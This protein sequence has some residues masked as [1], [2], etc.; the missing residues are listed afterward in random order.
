MTPDTS[1]PVAEALSSSTP[2]YVKFTIGTTAYSYNGNN[3]WFS[4]SANV[5]TQSASNYYVQSN[6]YN[7]NTATSVFLLSKK[8]TTTQGSHVSDAYFRN[9]IKTMGYPYAKALTGIDVKTKG[10]YIKVKDNAN[11]YWTSINPVNSTSFQ[12]TS[13]FNI[14]EKVEFV[15][16][17]P[18]LTV[19]FKAK[20]NC[21]LYNTLGDSIMLTNG[22]TITSYSNI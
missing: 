14:L 18:S 8:D 12:N 16:V 7:S 5:G 10:I 19:K 11:M 15:E 2:G 20:F 6:N 22:E 4:G 13:A 1:T 21:K 3:F 9:F 17:S